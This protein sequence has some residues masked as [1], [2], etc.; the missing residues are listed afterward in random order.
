MI[1]DIKK[2]KKWFLIFF[3]LFPVLFF[4]APLFLSAVDFFTEDFGAYVRYVM[5][6]YP[7]L[8]VFFIVVVL[9]IFGFT[10]KR[11]IS[12]I[13]LVI[14]VYLVSAIYI[15]IRLN[16]ALSNPKFMSW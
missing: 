5:Y 11:L 15:F 3:I 7:L 8:L 12:L 2:N 10:K 9:G 16:I 6:V 1:K 13:S 4:V 14:L